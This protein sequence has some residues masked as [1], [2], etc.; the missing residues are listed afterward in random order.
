ML[1]IRF[2]GLVVGFDYVYESKIN[3]HHPLYYIWTVQMMK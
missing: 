2:K 1:S 3:E